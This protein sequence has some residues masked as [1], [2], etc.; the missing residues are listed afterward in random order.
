VT[1]F[2]EHQ[3]T[4][5][6]FPD[7]PASPDEHGTPLVH[8][9]VDGTAEIIVNKIDLSTQVTGGIFVLDKHVIFKVKFIGP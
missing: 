3:V 9:K 1:L 5:A 4:L 8:K 7:F 2:V 6:H